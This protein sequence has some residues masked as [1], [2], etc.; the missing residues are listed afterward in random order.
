MGNIIIIKRDCIITSS[1]EG[2][3]ELS[4]DSSVGII[5]AKENWTQDIK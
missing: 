1:L 4:G 5:F 2:I 3:L